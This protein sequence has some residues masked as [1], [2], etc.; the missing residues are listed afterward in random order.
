MPYSTARPGVSTR[1]RSVSSRTCSAL[2]PVCSA[3]STSSRLRVRS[4][5]SASR[6]RSGIVPPALR[7]RLVQDHAAV[8]QDLPIPLRPAREQHCRGRDR[9]PDAGR[10]DARPDELHRVV[11]GQHRRHGAAGGVQVHADRRVRGV[12]LEVDELRDHGVGN[13]V[14]D[15]GAEVQDPVGE[16]SRVDVGGP[17]APL[18]A[19]RDV[20][21]RVTGHA[22]APRPIAWR[23]RGRISSSVLTT[24]STKP[25][26]SASSAPNQ[27]SR[28]ESRSTCATS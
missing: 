25:K 8:R 13:P 9:L 3:S 10:L 22:A 6:I 21:K 26:A 28:R 20:G 24:R 2:R 18:G 5:S 19:G 7:G 1:S 15:G 14:V 27:R 4:S 23:G 17:L 16:Q 12:R 11:D